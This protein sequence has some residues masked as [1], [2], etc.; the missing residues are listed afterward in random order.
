MYLCLNR[1]TF[2]TVT[3]SSMSPQRNSSSKR[4]FVTPFNPFKLFGAYQFPVE[5][6]FK[7]V[8]PYRF[9]FP[10]ASF[11]FPG[12][13]SPSA[14]RFLQS[15]HSSPPPCTPSFPPL[16]LAIRSVFLSH[17]RLY[18]CSLALSAIS[19]PTPRPP[20]TPRVHPPHPYPDGER[21]CWRE[22]EG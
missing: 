7:L 16:F 10:R 12:F 19:L 20:V 17:T 4:I 14:A 18:A 21:V 1:V 3:L 22:G 13:S 8:P 9:P 5:P 2:S 6:R 15:I 11:H